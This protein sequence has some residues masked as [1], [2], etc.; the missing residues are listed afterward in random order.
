M[1]GLIC[2]FPLIAQTGDYSISGVVVNAQTGEPVKYALV[3]LMAFQ[4]P[5]PQQQDKFQPPLQR[6]TQA[7]VA[8]EFQFK[9]LGKAR[10]NVSAQKPGFNMAFSPDDLKSRQFDLTASVSG[11]ELKLSPLGV[12]EGKV[13]DQNDEPLRGVN[14]LALQVQIND[15]DRSTTAPR[16]VA[17]DDRGM[18][19]LWNLQPGRYYIKAAGKSG[20]TYR[21]VG[22]GTPYYSSWPSF[23]PVY[24]GGGNTLD[25][26]TPVQIASGKPVTNSRARSGRRECFANRTGSVKVILASRRQV[27]VVLVGLGRTAL[28]RADCTLSFAANRLTSRSVCSPKGV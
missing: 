17:T 2:S 10:Y 28:R 13:V 3:T 12:I 11:V 14:I 5:D 19:R 6:S 16:S 22:D 15:G 18:Y 7:G 1:V 20:G 9:S 4:K 25:S 24:F 26:A 23:N 21:Y 27:L 8:G